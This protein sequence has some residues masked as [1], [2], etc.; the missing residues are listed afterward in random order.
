MIAVAGAGIWIAANPERGVLELVGYA[1]AGLGATFGP[2]LL[3]TLYMRRATSMAI[4]AGMVAGG[5]VVVGW[6]LII[7]DALPVYELLPAFLASGM[8]ILLIS[9]FA[10]EEA[11]AG[12]AFDRLSSARPSKASNRSG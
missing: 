1:W 2:A 6:P 5:A 12:D 3:A 10:A 8:T 4:V 11:T 7:G 9:Q